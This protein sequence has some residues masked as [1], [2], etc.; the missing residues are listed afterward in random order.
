[1]ASSQDRRIGYQDNWHMSFETFDLTLTDASLED[2]SYEDGRMKRERK[3]QG[4]FRM[5]VTDHPVLGSGELFRTA[6]ATFYNIE[7]TISAGP[8]GYVHQVPE[9]PYNSPVKN[10]HS[11]NDTVYV[12]VFCSDVMYGYVTA[13]SD[14]L[15]T[16][17][18]SEDPL[19]LNMSLH[20][21]NT[22]HRAGNKVRKLFGETF[23][24]NR[25][26]ATR[27]GNAGVIRHYP[28]SKLTGV[29][30]YEI[31]NL[32]GIEAYNLSEIRH[33]EFNTIQWYLGKMKE[34]PE[35]EEQK[36]ECRYYGHL[37]AEYRKTL[38]KPDID[39]DL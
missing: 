13:V 8:V 37:L 7:R 31:N 32:H 17:R 11:W 15:L 23:F 4:L 26:K 19:I 2:I 6:F 39:V 28:V 25:G 21:G 16:N 34:L 12:H 22:I 24:P 29:D 27:V 18:R 30:E 36:A 14:R 1:M 5:Y 35:T 9:R 33:T 3:L 38:Y 20:C 10:G